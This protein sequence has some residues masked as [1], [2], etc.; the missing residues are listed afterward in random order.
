MLHAILRIH[1]ISITFAA[2]RTVGPTYPDKTPGHVGPD[3]PGLRHGV[4]RRLNGQQSLL[5]VLSAGAA[6]A[7]RWA[8]HG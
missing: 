4:R 2:V 8:R 3:P 5:E 6:A 7:A 1:L